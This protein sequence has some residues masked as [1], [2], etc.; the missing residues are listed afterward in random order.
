MCKINWKILLLY[1][2]L[3]F[4]LAIPFID[5]YIP[6]L[7]EFG[8][9]NWN[10]V[11]PYLPQ[12]NNFF[13]VGSDNLLWGNLTWP[14]QGMQGVS[15]GI[16]YF[17]LML[18]LGLGLF[19]WKK[20]LNK[21]EILYR[22]YID[23]LL[24]TVIVI[25]LFLLRHGDKSL[26]WFIYKFFPGGSAIRVPYRINM[27][28]VFC[29]ALFVALVLKEMQ[30][31]KQQVLC[32]L[33]LIAIVDNTNIHGIISI[34]NYGEQKIVLDK[35]SSP[36]E[37]SDCFIIVDSNGYQ[38]SFLESNALA[39]QIANKYN[40]HTVNGYSGQYP[41]E[42]PVNSWNYNEN[43]VFEL[44][45]WAMSKGVNNLVYYDVSKNE[46]RD[47]YTPSYNLDAENNELHL[48]DGCIKG[49]DIVLN[50]GGS[51]YGPYVLLSAGTYFITVYTSQTNQMELICTSD[52]GEKIMNSTEISRDIDSICYILELEE[53]H[54]DVEF[55]VINTGNGDLTFTNLVISK[56]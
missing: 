44:I 29:I 7:H 5:I 36:P 17:T 2:I 15:L 46:W 30:I 38:K 1:F 32:F 47:S 54:Q 16:P 8:Q 21:K 53:N 31:K 52:Y 14:K 42:Y 40:I 12:F 13:D 6:L 23:A 51:S 4:I 35:V 3:A 18:F 45:N 27:L 41:P 10:I 20:T 55:K 24:L 19:A 26:W 56:E 9:R 50:K 48:L 49:K 34:W 33:L 25:W 43:L 28:V 22:N 39:W 37:D 11:Y